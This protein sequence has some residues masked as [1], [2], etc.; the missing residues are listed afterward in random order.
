MKR[1]RGTI[2]DETALDIIAQ[3]FGEAKDN[4]L[5]K[6][7][8]AIEWTLRLT[9]RLEPEKATKTGSSEN[10]EADTAQGPSKR[11]RVDDKTLIPE[12]IHTR[13]DGIE[14]WT[15]QH[16]RE[17]IAAIALGNLVG[18]SGIRKNIKNYDVGTERYNF[19]SD[20]KGRTFLSKEGV[21]RLKTDVPWKIFP[22]ISALF[23][24][25][26]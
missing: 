8:Y 24:N 20:T 13:K 12:S 2:S 26:I 5:S 15:D 6:R 18:L 11:Q 25:E 22:D 3:Q 10:E 4:E 9:G 19:V 14:I 17:W 21:R 7:L 23:S 1:Q 16:K